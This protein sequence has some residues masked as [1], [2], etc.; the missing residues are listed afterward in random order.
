[1]HVFI[2]V[3]TPVIKAINNIINWVSCKR[4]QDNKITVV[5]ASESGL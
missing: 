4:E 5:S 1:M 2:I 3:Q